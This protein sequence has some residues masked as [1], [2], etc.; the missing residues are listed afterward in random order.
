M[1]RKK[2]PVPN[3][4]RELAMASRC[5]LLV[6][7]ESITSRICPCNRPDDC[8]LPEDRRLDL[9]SHHVVV[10]AVARHKLQYR[11][12]KMKNA[13]IAIQ[14]Y[15]NAIDG[16][17]A[18]LESGITDEVK[19]AERHLAISADTL[20]RENPVVGAFSNDG[21]DRGR[22]VT[23]K[24][25]RLQADIVHIKEDTGQETRCGVDKLELAGCLV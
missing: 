7:S 16:L 15:Q 10:S 17:T 19:A 12:E 23:G 24:I 6:G 4:G 1:F 2:P 21:E 5:Q 8:C 25:L 3:S 18:S 20:Y 13:I 11:K 22:Y 14:Q 9:G